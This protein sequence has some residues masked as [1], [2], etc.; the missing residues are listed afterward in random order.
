MRVV[1]IGGAVSGLSAALGLARRGVD[2]VVLER[3]P[4]PGGTDFEQDFL[5]WSRPG[6]PQIR[7]GHFFLGRAQAVLTANAPDVLEALSAH[8]I[9]PLRSPMVM[10]F[11]DDVRPG[12]ELTPIP[13]RRIPLEVV[14]R[15]VASGEPTIEIRSEAQVADLLVD[16]EDTRPRVRGVQLA[17]GER[18]ESDFVIDACGNKSRVNAW[19]HQHGVAPPAD[20]SQ[21]CGGT[22]FGR[23]YRATGET[24]PDPWGLL[25]SQG[26]TDYLQ[27][28]VFPG[29]H[30]TY[31]V[32]LFVPSRD[33]ELRALRDDDAFERAARSFP[34]IA[35]WV[36]PATAEP[37]NSV[38]VCAGRD[39]VI[40]PFLSD[41]VPSYLGCLPVGDALCSTD[42]PLAWG[43]SLGLTTGFAIAEA[44]AK[45]RNDPGDAA[46]AYGEAVMDELHACFRVSAAA[47]R[48]RVRRWKGTFTG[49]EDVDEEMEGLFRAAAPLVFTDPD[50]VLLSGF[51]RRVNLVDPPDA[52]FGNSEFMRRARAAHAGG[53]SQ[54]GTAPTRDELVAALALD[55][56][57]V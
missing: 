7:Q 57:A 31:G 39:T 38:G 19:L 5:S 10:L 51:M 14:L 4:A 8:G 15:R 53:E 55:V 35:R 42:A 20:R 37:I 41:G 48:I 43:I 56:S 2:V 46:I 45:H 32:V 13:T 18:I 22:Y 29:D 1:V 23:Y 54:Q 24:P 9:T 12:D 49:P 3:D 26:M 30:G 36:D 28:G 47:A 44:I 6:V 27:Y 17:D 52:I 21:D 33:L 25:A 34:T 50:P 16:L 11:P 40:R